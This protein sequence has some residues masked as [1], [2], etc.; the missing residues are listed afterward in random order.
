MPIYIATVYTLSAMAE[1]VDGDAGIR[2]QV[3]RLE[4]RDP[5]DFEAS[6]RDLYISDPDNNVWFGPIGLSKEQV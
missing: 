2:R 3:H 4:A 1:A 6:I 5:K